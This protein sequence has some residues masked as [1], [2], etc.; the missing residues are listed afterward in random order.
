MDADRSDLRCEDW[1]H[2]ENVDD[3][4]S[5]AGP[6]CEEGARQ[7]C[8]HKHLVLQHTTIASIFPPKL[9]VAVLEALRK[10]IVLDGTTNR[11]EM[12]FAGPVS[13]EGDLREQLKGTLGRRQPKDQSR[14][15]HS[16]T[17]G[18]D[19]VKKHGVYVVVNEELCKTDDEP[20]P[21]DQTQ[22]SNHRSQVEICLFLSQDRAAFT[23]IVHELCQRMSNPTQRSLAKLTRL[24]RY[25][26]CERQWKQVL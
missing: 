25:L 24:V 10:Q 1:L 9:V 11:V 26:Q 5:C 15:A 23:F 8:S 14:S 7:Q 18:R 13:D 17:C 22:S 12:V 16:R 21:L 20:E 19:G 2:S 4:A 3:V 6:G